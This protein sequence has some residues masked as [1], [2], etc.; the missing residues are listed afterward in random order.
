MLCLSVLS[1]FWFILKKFAANV[2][3]KGFVRATLKIL[4]FAGER[5]WLLAHFSIDASK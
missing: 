4:N 3:L 2:T 1:D 5:V